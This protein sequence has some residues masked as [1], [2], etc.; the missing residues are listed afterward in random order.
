M[1]ELLLSIAPPEFLSWI[2]FVALAIALLGEVGVYI[3][4]P[5]WEALHG[6]AVFG[7]AA[8]AVAGYAV[9]RIGD[10]AIIDALKHRA[11]TAESALTKLKTP[12][13]LTPERQQFVAEAVRSFAGQRYETA[14]S[15]A[16]DDGLAFWESLYATLEKAGW[17]YLPAT[18]LSVGNP[19]AY[20]PIAAIPGVEI[21]FDPAKEHEL[22]LA[23]LAL[24]NALHA[25]GM[26]VAVNRN[27]ESNPDEAKRGRPADRDWRPG[28][29]TITSAKVTGRKR[30]RND[31]QRM[32][33]ISV[34]ILYS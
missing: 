27:R 14:I 16:A 19:P 3:I 10:D 1:N 18:S 26:E 13:T 6:A 31:A 5:K 21:R 24:G 28:A 15:Q 34:T 30:C 22:S 32:Q 9:E 8:L 29:V 20:L 25:D 11:T 7:F 4:P 2:G 17:V 33:R 23:A 12:R